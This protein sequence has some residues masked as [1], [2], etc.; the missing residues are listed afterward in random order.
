MRTR[1]QLQMH[2]Q[3]MGVE[4]CMMLL[5][6]LECS[7]SRIDKIRVESRDFDVDLIKKNSAQIIP[8]K[9]GNTKEW[10]IDEP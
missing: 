6:L 7:E 3:H 8:H 5:N 10:W 2:G 9:N 4:R 1:F